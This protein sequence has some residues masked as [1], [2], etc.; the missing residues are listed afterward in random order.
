MLE[1]VSFLAVGLLLLPHRIL[2]VSHDKLFLLGCLLLFF[3]NFRD[4][5]ET[6]KLS[7]VLPAG[8]GEVVEDLRGC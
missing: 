5:A 8:V 7:G 6:R 3:C 2:Q 1:I 4:R